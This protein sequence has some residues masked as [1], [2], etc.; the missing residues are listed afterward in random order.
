MHEKRKNGFD[1]ST[2]SKH[3]QTHIHMHTKLTPTLKSLNHFN[4]FT[5][6]VS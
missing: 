2:S 6:K 3:T 5:S 1:P 4:Q